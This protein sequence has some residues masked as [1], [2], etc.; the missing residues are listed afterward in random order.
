MYRKDQPAHP[1]FQLADILSVWNADRQSPAARACRRMFRDR[2]DMDRFF[3]LVW[4]GSKSPGHAGSVTHEGVGGYGAFDCVKAMAGMDDIRATADDFEVAAY[5]VYAEDA[6]Y[7]GLGGTE[8]HGSGILPEEVPAAKAFLKRFRGYT[9][10]E[11]KMAFGKESW[12]AADMVRWVSGCFERGIPASYLDELARGEYA[13]YYLEEWSPE[14]LAELYSEGTPA[15]FIA[16]FWT[17]P[18]KFD[19]LHKGGIPYEYAMVLD[20]GPER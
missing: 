3:G 4:P 13:R 20:E 2:T 9:A 11:L 19:A 10:E 1:D 17:R 12:R 8:A 5:L 15:V 14:F 18:A 6:Y 7:I 16:N